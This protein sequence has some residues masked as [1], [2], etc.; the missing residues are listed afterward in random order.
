MIEAMNMQTYK[1]TVDA[2]QLSKYGL[3]LDHRMIAKH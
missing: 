3:R 2:V 1:F